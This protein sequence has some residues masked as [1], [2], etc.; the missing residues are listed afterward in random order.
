MGRSKQCKRR[1]LDR[2]APQGSQQ[3]VNKHHQK[4]TMLTLCALFFS[5]PLSFIIYYILFF[6]R[7]FC[8]QNEDYKKYTKFIHVNNIHIFLFFVFCFSF[9]T[10]PFLNKSL[11]FFF[12]FFC[13]LIKYIQRVSLLAFGKS[14]C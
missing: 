10:H 5:L 13:D 9:K 4:K 6:S 3:V 12:L 8:F 7:Y 11:L 14:F 2:Q 1:C